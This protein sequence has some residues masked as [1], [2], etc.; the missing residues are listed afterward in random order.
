MHCFGI[1]SAWIGLWY[2]NNFRL[3]RN[4]PLFCTRSSLP[5]SIFLFSL[6]LFSFRLNQT[7]TSCE[8]SRTDCAAFP[9]LLIIHLTWLVQCWYGEEGETSSVATQF[10]SLACFRST[11]SAPQIDCL[12]AYFL[13]DPTPP[14]PRAN[15]LDP[16]RSVLM[17]VA[18]KSLP[19]LPNFPFH[20]QKN[21]PNPHMS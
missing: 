20:P 13:P 8:L 18:E 3:I 15:Y 6:G 9:V 14:L 21:L 4:T 7:M 19:F 17:K 5:C 16:N 1:K 12:P 2:K 11:Y 10:N